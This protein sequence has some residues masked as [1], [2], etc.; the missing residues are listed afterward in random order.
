MCYTYSRHK[1]I[2]SSFRLAHKEKFANDKCY[3][4][5]AEI[6]NTCHNCSSFLPTDI[7]TSINK[8]T[9]PSQHTINRIIKT[10][11]QKTYL[12][13]IEAFTDKQDTMESQQFKYPHAS[14][15]LFNNYYYNLSQ[16][17]QYYPQMPY[18]YMPAVPTASPTTDSSQAPSIYTPSN[19]FTAPTSPNNNSAYG[20]SEIDASDSSTPATPQSAKVNFDAC[21][22]PTPPS[23]NERS[24]MS[25]NQSSASLTS[26]PTISADAS[27]SASNTSESNKSSR[28]TK[29]RSRTQYSKQQIDCLEAIFLKS[30]YPEV[31]IVDKLSDKLNLSIERISVW[32][33]NRRAKFKKTKKPAPM[34]SSEALLKRDIDEIFSKDADQTNVS[35]SSEANIGYG[36]VGNNESYQANESVDT[37][38][39]V[40]VY[41]VEAAY[42][43]SEAEVTGINCSYYNMFPQQHQY[44]MPAMGI[45]PSYQN[46]YSTNQWYY[47]SQSSE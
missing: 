34:G 37:K 2:N 30:H 33:Q 1:K 5:I 15:E 6:N 44:Q 22:Y 18:N 11:I 24:G 32:F 35:N 12:Q 3:S 27:Y 21:C 29:R 28:V 19:T 39:P 45:N 41:P 31:H 20:N 14:S 9:E 42:K 36:S 23:E 38:S 7:D 17:Y 25:I 43:P 40:S 8:A 4:R 46:V 47:P 10:N 13:I 16:S 26:S